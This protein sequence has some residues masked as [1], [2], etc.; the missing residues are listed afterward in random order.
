MSTGLSVTV[1]VNWCPE[2]ILFDTLVNCPLRAAVL[3][4]D[5]VTLTSNPVLTEVSTVAV[6]VRVREV[7]WWMVPSVL[8]EMDTSGAGTEGGSWRGRSGEGE[9]A[10][11]SYH[12]V[13]AAQDTHWRR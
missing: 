11:T 7:P 8:R 12:T 5:H 1:R 10:H 13:T 9:T 2:P 6:Q 3:V 4:L